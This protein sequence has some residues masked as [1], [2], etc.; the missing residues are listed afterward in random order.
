ME[1]INCPSSE[2]SVSQGRLFPTQVEKNSQH[3]G[4]KI[5]EMAGCFL[6][7]NSSK[8]MAFTLKAP[9]HTQKHLFYF[10]PELQSG[11]RSHFSSALK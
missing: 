10:R 3:K 8:K 2:R 5:I 7:S 4:E 1:P 9:E 11:E 6:S